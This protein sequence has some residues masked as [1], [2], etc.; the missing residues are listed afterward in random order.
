MKAV[1]N[2]ALE[3][4]SPADLA[5]RHD[6]RLRAQLDYVMA[7]SAFYQRKFAGLDVEAVRGTADLARLPF[8]E[9]SELRES[10]LA[11]APFGHHVACAPQD[12]RRVYSTSG[13]TG[14]PTYIG[15]TRHDVEVWR[16]AATR[17]FWTNGLRPGQ[18]IPLVVS[19]FVVAA[20]Y[21]DAF[22]NIGTCM[23]IGVNMTDRLIDA[24]RF[25]GASA[26]LCTASYPLHFARALAERGIDP[27]SLGLELILAGGEPGASIPEVR[28][29][30]EGLFGCRL[31]ECSGNGDYCA[32][33]WAE[34]EH[35]QG[36]HFCAQDIIHPEIID[37]DSGEALPI[38]AGVRG[39]L[40]CTSLDREC[41]PLVRFRT[42]DHV[43]VTHTECDCGRTGFG[44]RIIGRTDD[45]LIVQGM[46]VYP[47][48]VRDVVASFAPATNGVIEI[49]LREA[50]PAGWAPPVH[51]KA[52][53]TAGVADPAA[54]AAAIEARLR[55]KLIFRARVELVPEM[56]LPRYEYKA[57]LVREVYKGA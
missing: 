19:P 8:T 14:R 40:V 33:A 39:E 52:E 2:P 11:V 42:R 25:G 48:A 17:A 5:A 3:C 12:V 49:Q 16:E 28:R 20:S 44:I 27:A 47:A 46:N 18:R 43:V 50:P 15:L 13:T 54:L 34:C 37:P 55:E 26:L 41:M 57:K 30:I 24:F 6:A 9:K 32:M 38:E 51:I 10:Q 53:V 23:P 21:A 56:A 31:M 7:R 45:L 36:M 35:R 1:W 4:A 22:E 29:Q